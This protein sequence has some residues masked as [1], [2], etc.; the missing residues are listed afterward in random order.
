KEFRKA[1]RDQVYRG[2]EWY[3]E[4]HA[5]AEELA[6]KNDVPL[7]QAAAVIAALSPQISWGQNVKV[8]RRVMAGDQE[9]GGVLG[10]NLDK[11]Y[12]ILAGEKI[13]DVIG[14][15]NS[16]SGHKVRSFYRCILTAGRDPHEVCIDR[17]AFALALGTRDTPIL[18]AK[19][20]RD[21]Q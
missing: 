9:V 16:K 8:A 12:R 13:S 15:K 18:T 2:L 21:T 11:A 5:L 17:H 6:L 4:A 20:Y 10:A 7:E 14:D 3:R 19:R 1:G